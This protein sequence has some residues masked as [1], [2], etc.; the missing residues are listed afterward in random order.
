MKKLNGLPELLLWLGAMYALKTGL[1][2]TH[3]FGHEEGLG[4]F[5]GES[6]LVVLLI[7]V[8]LITS[9]KTVISIVFVLV[10][11]GWAAQS[12][13]P[14]RTLFT[15]M[16]VVEGLVTLSVALVLAE[17]GLHEE[18]SHFKK[19][20]V[21]VVA[22]ALGAFLLT[23]AFHAG[24]LVMIGLSVMG[25]LVIAAA[26]G[27][28][29]PVATKVILAICSWRLRK[30]I[31]LILN[32]EAAL[33]DVIATLVFTI[34]KA[35]AKEYE[36]VYDAFVGLATYEGVTLFGTQAGVGLLVGAVGL[37]VLQILYNEDFGKTG[38]LTGLGLVQKTHKTVARYTGSIGPAFEFLIFF[39]MVP[40][41]FWVA[42]KLGG[43]GYLA[44][45]APCLV[46]G[47]FHKLE[48]TR[49]T[50]STIVLLVAK[51][52]IFFALGQLI[53]GDLF[54][55]YWR[56]GL[57]AGFALVVARAAAVY[58][59]SAALRLWDPNQLSWN[60]ATVIAFTGARGAVPA[61][62]M[63]LAVIGEYLTRGEF[64]IGTWAILVSIA[65]AQIFVMF[66]AP[67]IPNVREE[68]ET[69]DLAAND[70]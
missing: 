2:E 21:V 57:L 49:D 48:Q 56:E 30:R 33:N 55:A 3:L 52:F 5:M 47:Q 45:F 7:G 18:W 27:A 61:V 12:V 67:R 36:H 8:A 70:L 68:K 10:G 16:H 28:T 35:H 64:A 51:V 54:I 4:Q 17:S 42:E 60:E 62:L 66:G 50:F 43:N 40:G 59:V 13:E 31:E 1:A 44:V 25:S 38:F 32:G 63:A 46:F 41:L 9:G 39:G 20:I 29:D 23:C 53:A 24:L 15:H 11:L 34:F 14:F 37:L 69:P 22:F 6:F 65:S 26:L 19:A 58:L